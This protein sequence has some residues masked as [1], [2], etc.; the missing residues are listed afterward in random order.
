MSKLSEARI[1]A[2]KKWDE[3]NKDRKRYITYRSQAKSFIIKYA[4]KEDL[5]NLEKIITERREKLQFSID[6]VR[7]RVYYNKCKAKNKK[8]LYKMNKQ[9]INSKYADKLM[10][11]QKSMDLDKYDLLTIVEDSSEPSGYRVDISWKAGTDGD[12]YDSIDLEDIFL[13][14][15]D[16]EPEVDIVINEYRDLLR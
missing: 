9:E 16:V 10:N 6:C 15:F 5:D 7:Y 8:G 13:H 4:T 1:K 12:G 14:E 3:K 11:A 2:N